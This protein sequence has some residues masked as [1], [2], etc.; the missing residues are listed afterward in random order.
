MKLH[1]I[2]DQLEERTIEVSEN[3]WEKLASQLDAND[4][5]K[6][7]KSFYPY[8]AC[9]ALLISFLVFMMLKKDENSQENSI[10]NS[11]E[12]IKLDKEVVTPSPIIIKEEVSDK[13]FK[14][15][16]V[17]SEESM[18][19]KQVKAIVKVQKKETS[20]SNQQKE[21]L[22]VELQK[23]IQNAVAV[24]K[25]KGTPKVIE[26]IITQK[27]VKI[28]LDKDLRASIIALSATENIVITDEEIDQLLKEAKES[29]SELDIK[30]EQD[31]T[32]F[33]TADELLNEVEYELDKS[34]K[35]R[36]FDLIKKNVKKGKTLLADRN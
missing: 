16:L 26:T 20:I 32:R 4:Q 36:V 27:E 18:P 31:L 24:N 6:K 7:R 2:K 10:V 35:Q 23:E 22:E 9:L 28:D 30:K 12:T 34:F 5:K 3:S 15:A 33:A 17:A 1:N 13:L 11:E 25:N 21:Q 29:F 8:A 14:E 19:S